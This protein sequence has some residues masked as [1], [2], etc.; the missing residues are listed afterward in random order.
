MTFQPGVSLYLSTVMVVTKMCSNLAKMLNDWSCCSVLGSPY[1]ARWLTLT[2]SWYTGKFSSTV[3]LILPFCRDRWSEV[4]D[5]RLRLSSPDHSEEELV[6]KE[7]EVEN[8]DYGEEHVYQ[9]LDSGDNCSNTAPVYA[10][11]LK[12]KVKFHWK[13]FWMLVVL[14]P[15][16]KML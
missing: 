14:V 5:S 1:C 12:L 4:L 9:T 8:E 15:L 2:Q 10:L 16:V 7:E 11:P 3:G 13:G 6:D